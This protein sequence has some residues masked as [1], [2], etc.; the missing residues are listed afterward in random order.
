M[1]Q[2]KV[3]SHIFYI[4]ETILDKTQGI[5]GREKLIEGGVLVIPDCNWVHTFFI[6]L[7]LYVY[8]VSNDYSRVILAPTLSPFRLSPWVIDATH[9]IEAAQP[10]DEYII[11]KFSRSF[12]KI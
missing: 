4:A 5:I 6:S 11:K 10:L 9:V 2:I 7:P 1:K 8:F 12:F 3:D